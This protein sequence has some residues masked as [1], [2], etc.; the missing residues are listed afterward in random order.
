MDYYVVMKNNELL[1]YKRV[2]WGW[3]LDIISNGK[4]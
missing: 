3:I 4:S 2:N 1:L